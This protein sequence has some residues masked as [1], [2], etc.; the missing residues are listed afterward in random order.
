M[1]LA[2][3]RNSVSLLP[4]FPN[5]AYFGNGNESWCYRM[6]REGGKNNDPTIMVDERGVFRPDGEYGNGFD[7]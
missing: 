3:E 6:G 5:R 2:V 4:L 7:S 1:M